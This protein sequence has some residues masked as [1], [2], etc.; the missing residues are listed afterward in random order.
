MNK[1]Q[2]GFTLVE[3]VVVILILG[4]LSAT[5]LPRFMNVN[6]QAH[7][8]AV[9]GAG[10]GFG[11]GIALAHAQWVANGSSTAA[12]EIDDVAGFGDG[13][14]DVSDGSVAGSTPGWP[15]DVA[16]TN[17]VAIDAAAAQCIA[18]WNGIMQNPP[19]VIAGATTA[20]FT[21]VQTAN[22]CVYSYNP[23]GTTFMSITYTVN[24]GGVIVDS[25]SSS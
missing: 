7:E 16:G 21:A 22:Q 20:D 10:G 15:T 14:V 18:I 6:T 4:I 12:A 3:L 1:S 9:S 17:T 5:A 8:A 11:A 24:N 23:D 19:T 13:L 25:D 2:S